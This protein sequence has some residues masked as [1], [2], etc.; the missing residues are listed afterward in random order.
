MSAF[1]RGNVVGYAYL[2]RQLALQIPPLRCEAVITGV[3]GIHRENGRL[4]VPLKAAP[5]SRSVLD[6]LM[7]ALK[8]EGTELGVLRLSMPYLETEK[9]LLR[10]HIQSHQ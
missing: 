9:F 4:L 7:F 10:R 3:T 8:H 6:N 2:V 1:E 5:A